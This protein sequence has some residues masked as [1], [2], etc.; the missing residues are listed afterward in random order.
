[1]K[2]PE[3]DESAMMLSLCIIAIVITYL[4]VGKL[5][6][7]RDVTFLVAMQYLHENSQ[8]S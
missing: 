1:M 3:I 6:I 7:L 5:G 4:A 2:F 8:K